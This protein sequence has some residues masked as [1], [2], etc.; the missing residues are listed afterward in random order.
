L[1][2]NSSWWWGHTDTVVIDIKLQSTLSPL[3]E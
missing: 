2:V 3:Q 1:D